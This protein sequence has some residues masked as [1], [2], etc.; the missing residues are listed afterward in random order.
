MLHI[1]CLASFGNMWVEGESFCS[2]RGVMATGVIDLQ[3]E[4]GWQL[5]NRYA[6]IFRYGVDI[7]P[8]LTRILCDWFILVW[9]YISYWF[10]RLFDKNARQIILL[11]LPHATG[12]FK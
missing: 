8:S 2:G 5:W 10:V 7:L 9:V 6:I 1:A 12:K 3:W 11:H 4:L